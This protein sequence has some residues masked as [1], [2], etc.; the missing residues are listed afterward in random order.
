LAGIAFIFSML[1]KMKHVIDGILAM[2]IMV[3]FIGQAIGIVLLRRKNGSKH[4]AYKMPLYPIP[5]ILVII[6]W[7][8]IFFATGLAI[9][10]SFLIVF[11]SGVIVY[12]IYAR[13]QRQWPYLNKKIK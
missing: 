7:L 8:F 9:I 1:F 13:V 4:L 3:Q 5:I 12:F 10:L 2:R 6:M 11:I